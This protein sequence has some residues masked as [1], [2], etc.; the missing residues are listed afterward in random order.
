MTELPERLPRGPTSDRCRDGT[1]FGDRGRPRPGD[2]PVIAVDIPSGIDG[3]TGAVGGPV[4]RAALTVTFAALKPGLVLDPGRELVGRVEVADIGLDVS[5]A[6]SHLVEDVDVAAWVPAR[7]PD[8]HKWRA[9]V[10]VV[11][12][13]G[14]MTG[15]AHLAARGAQ[16]AGAG[17]VRLG[18]PA[19]GHDPM[20]PVEVVGRPLPPAPWQPDVLAD[21]DRFHALVVDGAA[22]P[23]PPPKACGRSRGG[24]RAGGGRRGGLV[25]RGGR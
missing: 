10:W 20:T 2:T 16:R 5:R 6:R 4:M 7:R 1:D 19:L 22:A 23:T 9:A 15:A 17:M 25:A 21:L 18:T 24:D 14:G 12:G 3:L 13:S 8:A 11:A